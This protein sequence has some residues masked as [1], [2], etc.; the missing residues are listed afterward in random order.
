MRTEEHSPRFEDLD[1]WPS[2]EAVKAMFEGQLSAVAAVRQALPDIVSAGEAAAL[3]LA[4]AGRLVDAGAGTSGRIGVQD[5]AELSPTFDWP[6]DR[7]AFAVAGGERAL[8]GRTEAESH[9]DPKGQGLSCSAGG[10]RGL[11]GRRTAVY[12]ENVG[13]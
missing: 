12:M 13:R 1:A 8:Q 2:L 10:R 3:R 4:E 11:V 5:G 6:E 9:L 7:V